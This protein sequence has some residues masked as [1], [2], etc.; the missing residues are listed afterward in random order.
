MK[1]KRKTKIF[2]GGFIN[3]T[4]AQNL[5]CLALAKYLDKSKYE[6]YTMA[7]ENG[8]FEVAPI[9]G[10]HIIKAKLPYRIFKY[11]TWLKGVILCDILYLPKG[12]LVRYLYFWQKLFGKKSFFTVEGVYIKNNDFYNTII[13]KYKSENKI[14]NIFTKYDKIYSITSF[15]IEPNNKLFN[16]KSESKVLYLGTEF[17]KFNTPNKIV[18][19]LTNIAIIGGDLKRKGIADFIEISTYFPNINFHIIGGGV[20]HFDANSLAQKYNNINYHG[21]IP[22]DKLSEV[23]KNVQLMFF[24]SRCE[25]FPKVTLE[26]ASAGV[27]CIV[28]GDYGASEWIT[29]GKDGFV[30]NTLDEAK[31]IIEDLVANP[32]KVKELSKNAVELGRSFDWKNIIKDWETEI[33]KLANS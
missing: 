28:Y 27:P 26:C 2:L 15:M 29:T 10:V 7:F 14:K 21:S 17:T 22:H 25:G 16:I 12:E 32:D 33:D 3:S 31:T 5:N 18:K 19:K 9:E 20:N 23:L 8:D 13:D 30:V 11:W 6:I 24:P 4:N 1:D